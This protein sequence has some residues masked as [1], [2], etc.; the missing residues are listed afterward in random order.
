MTLTLGLV[1]WQAI[2]NS[3]LLHR[4]APTVRPGFPGARDQTVLSSP[5]MPVSSPYKTDYL[6]VKYKKGLHFRLGIS[7]SSCG[8]KHFKGTNSLIHHCTRVY[9]WSCSRK[10]LTGWRE[11]NAPNRTMIISRSYSRAQISK[12]QGMV[13]TA[14]P[15]R[16]M[17]KFLVDS[18]HGY[19]CADLTQ[20]SVC[21]TLEASGVWGK[22]GSIPP[23]SLPL[24][25]IKLA[26]ACCLPS[27]PE[28]WRCGHRRAH[29]MQCQSFAVICIP[30][31]GRGGPSGH[32]LGRACA[33]WGEESKR[34]TR[35]ISPQWE[36]T[37]KW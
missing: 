32:V 29:Q 8:N 12:A 18:Y 4:L 6:K 34:F 31:Q 27:H 20:P 33:Q 11:Y 24:I 21:A 3:F 30:C 28:G 35:F 16:L 22:G 25:S 1:R 2:M 37:R 26:L 17:H 13:L 14:V 9:T 10:I 19:G 7:W 23:F 36:E 5:C 15:K